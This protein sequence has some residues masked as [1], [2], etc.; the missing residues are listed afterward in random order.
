MKPSDFSR[1]PEQIRIKAIRIVEKTIDSPQTGAYELRCLATN[2]SINDPQ[3]SLKL[4][5]I[6][7]TVDVE[8]AILALESIATECFFHGNLDG[9]NNLLLQASKFNVYSRRI[10]LFKNLLPASGFS[11]ANINGTWLAEVERIIS[12]YPDAKACSSILCFFAQSVQKH[13][14]EIAQAIVNMAILYDREIGAIFYATAATQAVINENYDLAKE[15]ILKALEAYPE[16]TSGHLVFDI[17][18]RLPKDIFFNLSSYHHVIVGSLRVLPTTDIASRLYYLFYNYSFSNP[19]ISLKELLDLDV[20]IHLKTPLSLFIN[21]IK[22]LDLRGLNFIGLMVDN[23]LITRELLISHGIDTSGILFTKNDAV[24]LKEPVRRAFILM[25]LNFQA[26]QL[27]EAVNES[28]YFDSR[29]L[30]DAALAG[31]ITLLNK[32]LAAGAD[33]L[34]KTHGEYPLE[35]AAGKG[36]MGIIKQLTAKCNHSEEALNA[37]TI[38]ARTNKHIKIME[39]LSSTPLHDAIALHNLDAVKALANDI[40]VNNKNLEGQTPLYC[41]AWSIRES[42]LK[43]DC[44]IMDEL[45]K[46]AVSL[47][48]LYEALFLQFNNSSCLEAQVS[49]LSAWKK[50]EGHAD[51]RVKI[52]YCNTTFIWYESMLFD[53][54]DFKDSVKLLSLFEEC[55]ADLNHRNGHQTLL[56]NVLYRLNNG[57][58]KGRNRNV[59][60]FL[61]SRKVDVNSLDENGNAQLHIYTAKNNIFIIEQ[62]VQHG[63]N[64][65]LRNKAGQTALDIALQNKASPEVIALLTPQALVSQN[66]SPALSSTT[67]FFKEKGGVVGEEQL[68][69]DK[70]QLN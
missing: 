60:H 61:F 19:A 48:D 56:S 42:P 30:Y 11:L 41:V 24:A 67:G 8:Q 58:Q 29:T 10:G 9:A 62:L 46:Y 63:A 22:K 38:A 14:P 5:A 68:G 66:T 18:E 50:K 4:I 27:G 35:A 47:E 16:T 69:M 36:H 39:M 45:L 65:T 2:E 55:G 31:D 12:L 53:A 23:Q 49:L 15:M 64:L 13:N 6:I 51:Y 17:Y 7:A 54:L 21:K 34:T 70:K 3:A 44:Q 59:L 25:R 40:T 1:I 28:D 57:Y 43:I 32:R 37:A 26:K 52:E 33:P 20:G